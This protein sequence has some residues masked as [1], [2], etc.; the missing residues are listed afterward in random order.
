MENE[1]SEHKNQFYYFCS[2]IGEETGLLRKKTLQK[3]KK[4]QSFSQ[5]GALIP[6]FALF[7]IMA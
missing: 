2:L 3:L 7:F 4:S 5:E 1:Y 6:L